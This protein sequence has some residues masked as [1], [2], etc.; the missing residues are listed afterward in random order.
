MQNGLKLILNVEV[1]DYLSAFTPDV[2]VKVV[3]HPK[4]VIPFP[5]D[6]GINVP[7]GYTSSIGVKMVQS[8]TRY[9]KYYKCRLVCGDTLCY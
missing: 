7:P 1:E 4:D 6:S 8:F 3:V 2:G 5:E 9:N